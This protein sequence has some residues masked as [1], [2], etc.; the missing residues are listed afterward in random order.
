MQKSLAKYEFSLPIGNIDAY[1]YQVNAIPMLSA[2]EERTLALQWLNEQD[3][4][5]ARCLVMAHLRFVVR[6]AKG[7]NGYGLQLADLIQEGN[8]GLMKA[9]KRFNPDLGVR[10]ISFAVHWIKAEMREF[11][12]QNWRIVK[13]ATTKAQR[14]LFFNLRSAKKRLGWFNAEEVATVA[15]D[16]GVSSEQ[17]MQMEQRM[18]AYDVAFD[19][20]EH[21]DEDEN[22]Q[23]HLV[24]VEYLA[25][26]HFDPARLLE[27]T[28][29]EHQLQQLVTAFAELDERS[30]E[31]LQQRW[32]T[33]KKATLHE[34]AGKYQISAERIRQLEHNALKKLK[35]LCN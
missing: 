5:A 29:S 12:L 9:V 8:I 28:S 33:D 6:I 4:A 10:L 20:H 1:I 34:L 27:A 32:L 17:V 16:L 19:S 11:I 22:D 35:E 13:L 2:Q 3:L 14:K 18:Q 23:S 15:K 31:I 7:F 24:P 25:D 21:D 26:N 30:R